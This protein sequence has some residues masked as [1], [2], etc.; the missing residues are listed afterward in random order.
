MELKRDGTVK[1]TEILQVDNK[2]QINSDGTIEFNDF[3]ETSINNEIVNIK[4]SGEITAKEFQENLEEVPVMAGLYYNAIE[5]TWFF[6][7]DERTPEYNPD[8]ELYLMIE[9]SGRQGFTVSRGSFPSGGTVMNPNTEA[10]VPIDNILNSTN[11]T[12]DVTSLIER[13]LQRRDFRQK[14]FKEGRRLGV[15]YNVDLEIEQDFFETR[16]LPER[17]GR[18]MPKGSQKSKGYHY[19]KIRFIIGYFDGND[20]VNGKHRKYQWGEQGKDGQD[21]GKVFRVYYMNDTNNPS[22]KSVEVQ[23]STIIINK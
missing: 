1:A 4:R 15:Q 13:Q 21:V 23:N 17:D 5:E 8:V 14:Q 16:I 22:T 6:K 10:Y 19:T 20:P 7:K 9:T 11:D 3:N 2:Q 18:G 12:I